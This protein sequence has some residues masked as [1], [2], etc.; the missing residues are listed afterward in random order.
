M[1][2]HAAAVRLGG[3]AAEMAFFAVLGLFPGLLVVAGL[4]GWLDS[5]AGG[6]AAGKAE[7]AAVAFL[8]DILTDRAAGVITAV[9]DLFERERGGVVLSALVVGLWA[10]SRGFAAAIRALD[11]AYGVEERR[12]W[13][14]LTATAL[15]LALGSSVMAALVLL[16]FGV[17]PLLGHGG[18]L[19]ARLGMGPA[20]SFAWDWLR[21][22]FTL[23]L[24]VAW[25]AAI[26]RFGPNHRAGWRQGL[27]GAAAAGAMWMLLSFGFRVYLGLAAGA[28]RVFGV[29]GGGLILLVA[30]YLFSL[31]LLIGGE[32]NAA[33][34]RRARRVPEAAHR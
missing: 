24:L 1:A 3:L 30:C 18:D 5:L 34:R 12:G 19:A 31:A 29:L 21:G 23:A 9:R 26:Y 8:Q 4:L 2:S 16:M 27:P 32:L 14:D 25:I 15:A 22:P 20:F 13:L 33:L 11:L 10:M 17:G 28:N 6:E 7:A